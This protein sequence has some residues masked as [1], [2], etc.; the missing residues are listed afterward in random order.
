MLTIDELFAG[1]RRSPDVEAPN[2]FA[3]DAADRLILDLAAE[4]LAAV[5]GSQ[6]VV[7]GDHY[8]AL[9]LGTA[10]SYG[11]DGIRVHQDELTGERALARNADAAGLSARYRQCDVDADLLDGARVILVQL[12]RSLGALAEI[13]DAI[14]SFA[15]PEVRVYAGGRDKHISVAMN[16]VLAQ[17]FERVQASRGRQKSRVLTVSGPTPRAVPE[18]PVTSRVPDLDLT[19]VAHGAAFAGAKLDI[20]TRYLLDFLPRATAG[21]TAVDLGCG[22][23]ILAVALKRLRPDVTVIA[24]DQSAAAVASARATAAANGVDVD[25]LRDDAM[26]SLPDAG[27]DLIVCN[28]PFH[29]GAAVHTGAAT[30]MFRA[31]GRVLRPGGEMWTVYN[32]HLNYRAAL[33]RSVGTTEVM[34][35]NA[36]FT[37]VRS[38]RDLP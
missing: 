34:G 38:T 11:L 1:L 30:K 12:P 29:V 37:V 32:T 35:R 3:V 33:A 18:Y 2:L 14:A 20:G 13:A 6:I 8:G 24:T 28:P 9:T 10:A 22:T 36:K 19:V 26:A 5:A 25:V 21:S 4:S 7:I 16:D 31:A 23:G 17:R 27:T 15:D